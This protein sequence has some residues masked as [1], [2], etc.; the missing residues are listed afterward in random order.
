MIKE[1]Q[2]KLQTEMSAIKA[3]TDRYAGKSEDMT[4]EDRQQL[5]QHVT[6]GEAY[7]QE[8]ESLQKA[9][10][11]KEFAD[12]PASTLPLAGIQAQPGQIKMEG[13][14]ESGLTVFEREFNNRDRVAREIRMAYEEGECRVDDKTL[15][16]TSTK[17]YRDSYRAYLR[18]GKEGVTSNQLKT[19]QEGSDTAGGFLVPPDIL[20]RVIAK[21]PTPTRIAGRVTRLQTMRDR[22][23]IPKVN[24]TTDDLYT[25]GI[26][27]TWTGEIP[28]SATTHRVTDP[29]FGQVAIPIHT[30]MLSMPITNDM[31]EDSSFPLVE[32]SSGKFA[33]TIDL[34]Y[35]NMILNGNGIGQPFGILN[36]PGG[37]NQP[38][39]VVSTNGSAVTWAGLQNIAFAVPEQYDD[40]CVW[41]F[42]KTSTALAIS[43]LVD[44]QSRPFWSMGYEDSGLI[45]SIKNRPLLGYPVLYSGFA[46]NIAANAFPYIFGDPKGYYHVDRIGF[47]IQ[48]LNELYAESNQ[49]LLLGRVRFGGQVAEDWRLKIG[50]CSA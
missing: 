9:E 21:K 10:A 50:K 5:M 6:K 32:W 39:V 12:E 37:A 20:N 4:E 17:D 31:I 25:T 28:A 46:P 13:S 27:V 8:I 22:L 36:N 18:K 38:A 1:I 7:R 14:Y 19:L 40:D 41:I 48:V 42:N 15:A 35:D 11:L 23:L 29:I 30:A 2:K 26:R 47:S 45:P 16:A 3:I 44:G 33:E 34:L 49:K 43:K 24:Y